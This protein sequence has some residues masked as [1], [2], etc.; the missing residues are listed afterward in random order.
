[1]GWKLNLWARLHDGNHAYKLYGNLLK[2]GTADNLWDMHPP[3]QIDGNFGGTAGI[4]E[5]LMQS[6]T[7]CIHLLPALP[8][9]WSEGSV[10]GLM[11]RGNFGI[12]IAWKQGKATKATVTSHKGGNCTIRYGNSILEFPTKA[13]KQYTLT[14]DNNSQPALQ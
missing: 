8:D 13:G 6:H 9:A 4:I 5:M 11:A 14:F 10:E 3:F 1:M 7:G 2:N 12:D